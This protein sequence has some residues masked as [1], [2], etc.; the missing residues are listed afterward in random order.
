VWRRLE[1]ESG[2]TLGTLH[3]VLQIAFAWEDS[4]VHEFQV[5]VRRFGRPDVG[6]GWA[7]PGDTEDGN[8]RRSAGLRS[9]SVMALT[10]VDLAHGGS[11]SRARASSA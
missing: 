8:G 6:D 2:S 3:A 7:E 10:S 5:G 9:P 11:A 4:H 1:V